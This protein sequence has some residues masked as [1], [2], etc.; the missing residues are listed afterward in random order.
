MVAF[1]V[2]QS[3]GPGEHYLTQRD[4]AHTICR[5]IQGF[6]LGEIEVLMDILAITVIH[7]ALYTLG[8]LE[9]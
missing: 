3:H 1:G 9:K 2:F 6:L 5:A 4:K 7:I 8:N